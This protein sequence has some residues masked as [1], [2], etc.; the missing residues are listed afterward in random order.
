MAELD[1]IKE[2]SSFL[3]IMSASTRLSI[4]Y[5]LK[6]KERNVTDIINI[7]GMEQSAISHQL[8]I[9]KDSRLIRSRREGKSII[10][11]LD[12]HHIFDILE[13]VKNHINEE[14][15]KSIGM[16]NGM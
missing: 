7:T 3:K 4:L 11:Q 16:N 8:R 6:E 13:Q 12:D 14:K 1:E 9:L 10:Y 15:H 5:I 2:I